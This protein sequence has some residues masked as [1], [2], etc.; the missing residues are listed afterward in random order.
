MNVKSLALAAVV[1]ALLAWPAMAAGPLSP[2][3][4]KATFGTGNP[5][6]GR[7]SGGMTYT[8]TLNADGSSQLILLKGAKTTSTG[9][10]HVSKS[11]YCSK[12]GSN[13]THCYAIVKN[14]KQY[15]VTDSAGK[16]VA[17]WTK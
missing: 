12:W 9:A 16:V 4:I 8:L 7:T 13:P 6:S 3:E 2:D 14:G 1:A 11:G 10:W 17:S 15:D 5:I